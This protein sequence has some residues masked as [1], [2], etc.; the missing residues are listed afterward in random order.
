LVGG[1]DPSAHKVAEGASR[2]DGDGVYD[3]SYH[4]I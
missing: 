2:Y 1:A 4:D 3:G